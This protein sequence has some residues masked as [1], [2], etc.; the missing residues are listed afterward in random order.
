MKDAWVICGIVRSSNGKYA[1][2][3]V[4]YKEYETKKE[5]MAK[6]KFGHYKACFNPYVCQLTIS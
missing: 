1:N 6:A 4:S 2:E 5:A 3:I